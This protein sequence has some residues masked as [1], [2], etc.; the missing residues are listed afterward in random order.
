[1]DHISKNIKPY[2]DNFGPPSKEGEEVREVKIEG[3]TA[4]AVGL[5][6]GQGRYIIIY[7]AITKR[8]GLTLLESALISTIHTL[9]KKSSNCCYMS[10]GTFANL[11]NVSIPTIVSALDNLERLGL[12]EKSATKSHLKTNKLRVSLEVKI[13]VEEIRAQIEFN[14]KIRLEEAKK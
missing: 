8:F 1:M 14:K 12:V 10:Q 2:S 6:N 11:F 3:D 5:S 9:S 13:L 4:K 7:H